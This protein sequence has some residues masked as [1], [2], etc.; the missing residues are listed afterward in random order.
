VGSSPLTIR[1]VVMDAS[2]I[3]AVTINGRSVTIRPTSAQAAEFYS[4]PMALH[5]GENSF[6]VSATD[7]NHA[8]TKVVFVA[9]FIP[10][11]PK[12]DPKASKGL[13]KDE[14]LDLLRGDVPSARVADL[15][16]ERGIKFVPSE[17]DLNEIRT[18]GGRDDLILALKQAPSPVRN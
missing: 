4:D 15:V 12:A 10:A 7:I 1:G 2:G 6:E 3:P 11:P 9:R 18:A 14:I 16:T 5:P 13:A 8:E 17:N